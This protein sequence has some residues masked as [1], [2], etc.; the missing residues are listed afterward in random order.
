M[1]FITFVFCDIKLCGVEVKEERIKLG[2]HCRFFL[3][4]IQT[5]HLQNTNP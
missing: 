2:R 4:E 5:R 1:R 3:A